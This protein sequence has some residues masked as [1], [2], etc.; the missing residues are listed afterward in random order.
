MRF[1]GGGDCGK[2]REEKVPS[3]KEYILGSG[4]KTS[5]LRELSFQMIK[6]RGG[7]WA[8]LGEEVYS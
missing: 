6:A 3:E 4:N 2:K 1:G 7:K 5:F 8:D